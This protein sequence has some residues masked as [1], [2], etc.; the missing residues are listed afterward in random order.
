MTNPVAG[1]LK[2]LGCMPLA[3]YTPLGLHKRIQQHRTCLQGSIAA[4]F[5]LHHDIH[6]DSILS[7]VY[8]RI[9]NYWHFRVQVPSAGHDM[10]SSPHT[11]YGT[12]D[13]PLDGAPVASARTVLSECYVLPSRQ[14]RCLRFFKLRHLPGMDPRRCR[15]GAKPDPG[16]K[17]VAA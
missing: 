3:S 15:I 12:H 10:T 13:Q 11:I 16:G 1:R 6:R 7:R 9:A 14:L 17:A 5:H 8:N 4:A 2:I